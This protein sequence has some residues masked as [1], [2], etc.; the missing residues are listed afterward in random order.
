MLI[1]KH[2]FYLQ[3]QKEKKK[4]D[5]RFQKTPKNQGRPKG[6]GQKKKKKKTKVNGLICCLSKT[7]LKKRTTSA[8]FL[9]KAEVLRIAFYP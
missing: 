3:T 6:V 7:G 9:K 4:K 5:S 1:L 8:V 2:E